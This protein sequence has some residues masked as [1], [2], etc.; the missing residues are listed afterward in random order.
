MLIA[1]V[2]YLIFL[3]VFVVFSIFVLYHLVKYSFGGH[4]IKIMTTIFLTGIIVIF[5]ATLIFLNR[6]DLAF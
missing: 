6:A 3:I 1:L 5:I 4:F 2:L